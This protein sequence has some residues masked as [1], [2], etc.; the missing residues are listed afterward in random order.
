MYIRQ[1]HYDKT[2]YSLQYFHD[3]GNV[4]GGNYSILDIAVVNRERCPVII[5]SVSLNGIHVSFCTF[6]ACSAHLLVISRMPC[7]MPVYYISSR[8]CHSR[9]CHSHAVYNWI[10]G[11]IEDISSFSIK[12]VGMYRNEYQSMLWPFMRARNS[13]TSDDLN[14]RRRSTCRSSNIP[15]VAAPSDL[16]TFQAWTLSPWICTRCHS[17]S[18]KAFCWNKHH[19]ND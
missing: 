8:K 14:I 13:S 11:T 6:S 2:T 16:Y 4:T 19:Y 3:F 9:K 18:L 15:R 1:H 17:F 7:S 10:P 12:Y 5:T